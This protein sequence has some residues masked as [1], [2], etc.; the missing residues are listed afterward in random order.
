MVTTTI[1]SIAVIFKNCY[2]RFGELFGLMPLPPFYMSFHLNFLPLSLS[3]LYL[4][5][6]S[7]PPSASTPFSPTSL[8]LDLLWPCLPRSRPPLAP[9]PTSLDLGS[10]WPHLPRP[11]PPLALPPSISALFGPVPHLPRPRPP[12]A[13]PPLASA[14]L[15]PLSHS[16]IE[17][18][19]FSFYFFMP[20][21]PSPPS[22][23]VL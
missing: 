22:I 1:G 6:L 23:G 21:P 4:R 14:P 16:L 17:G 15:A 20:P 8:D 12:L 11:Q 7:S 19:A 5:T 3:S 18:K 13:P 10:L 2:Y 9:C